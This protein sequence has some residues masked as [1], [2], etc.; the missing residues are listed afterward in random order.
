MT[1]AIRSTAG[2]LKPAMLCAAL[3]LLVGGCDQNGP[4]TGR[5]SDEWTR[6]YALADGGALQIVA[7]DGSVDVQGG[8]G[9]RVEVRAERIAKASTDAEAR[10][11][12]PRIEIREDVSP[13][14][15]GLQTEGLGHVV[16]GVEVSVQYHVTVPPMTH[17]HVRA[18]NGPITLTDLDGAV[19]ASTA[20][21]E[22]VGHDLTG[23]VSLH[24]DNRSIAL[25]L[26]TFT[27]HP[28]DL[29]ATTGGITLGIPPDANANLLADSNSGAIDLKDLAFEPLGDQTARRI[30]GR[31]NAGGASIEV[32]T[33][34]GNIRIHP[35][36]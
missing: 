5:A 28:I 21:G 12:L 1:S 31:I 14:R 36:Q 24:A 6:S 2:R 17:V 25:D 35:R 3:A 10:A 19:V 18:A 16:I 30:R 33:I 15:I 23:S 13:D 4:L 8:S 32:A 7:A 26:K 27:G 29:R 34:A 20:D 22:I 9:P 11:L